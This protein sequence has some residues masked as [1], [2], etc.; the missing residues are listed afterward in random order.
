MA[1]LRKTRITSKRTLSDKQRAKKIE[2]IIAALPTKR[3]GAQ[4]MIQAFET[5]KGI[6]STEFSLFHLL[7]HCTDNDPKLLKQFH[8]FFCKVNKIIRKEAEQSKLYQENLAAIN[9]NHFLETSPLYRFNDLYAYRPLPYQ[10]ADAAYKHCLD[11]YDPNTPQTV[12]GENWAGFYSLIETENGRVTNVC[13]SD[14][15]DR[16]IFWEFV[17]NHD[18]KEYI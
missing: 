17:D 3:V 5:I 12:V 7:Q 11:Y 15:F 16:E 4:A 10:L 1:T 9:S 14:T 18:W 6:V 13:L 8:T 2:Q